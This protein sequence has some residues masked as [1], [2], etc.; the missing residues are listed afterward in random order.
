M[1]R[2]EKRLKRIEKTKTKKLKRLHYK[3]IGWKP[4]SEEEKENAV[5][6]LFELVGKNSNVVRQEATELLEKITEGV[7]SKA[8]L[9]KTILLDDE[10][11]M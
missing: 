5:V 10:E 11:K 7:I 6:E 2:K 1:T 9:H 3:K 8:T 4:L